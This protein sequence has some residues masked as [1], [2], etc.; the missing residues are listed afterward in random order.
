MTSTVSVLCPVHDGARYLAAALASA[1]TQTRAADEIIVVDDG[2]SDDSAA[3]AESFADVRVVR[4]PHRG[5]AATRNTLV[6][7]ARGELVA[8][9]DAD[10]IWTPDKLALQVDFMRAHPE[11]GVS[12][13]HQRMRLEPDVARPAWVSSA[14]LEQPTPALATCSMI[15]RRALFDSVGGFDQ[16][17]LRGEDT[18]W[19]LRATA[20]G[21]RHAVLP[22]CLLERRV[23]AHNL[24]HGAPAWSTEVFDHLRKA[25]RRN[26]DVR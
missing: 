19:L 10:D 9:L 18:D 23:H 7:A 4:A 12:Y 20:A 6:A 15:A 24:S 14:A 26:R 16:T 2:S 22:E 13:T 5:V 17:C 21:V 1:R 25:V 11:I 8:F 3:I